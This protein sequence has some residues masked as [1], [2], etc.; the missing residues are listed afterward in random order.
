MKSMSGCLPVFDNLIFLLFFLLWC[1]FLFSFL[2]YVV[3]SAFFNQKIW[4]WK[5]V[6]IIMQDP[7][8]LSHIVD[9]FV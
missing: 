4:N 8:I 2:T 9:D 6:W 5:Y 3:I 1:I 7:V